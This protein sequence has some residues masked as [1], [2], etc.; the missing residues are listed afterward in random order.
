MV[1]AYEIRISVYVNVQSNLDRCLTTAFS[2]QSS[3]NNKS[4][5]GMY[6]MVVSEI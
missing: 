2:K 1:G 4:K 3:I 6:K 5:G